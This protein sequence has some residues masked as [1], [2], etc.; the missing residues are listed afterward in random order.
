MSVPN[1]EKKKKKN[2]SCSRKPWGQGYGGSM[3][4]HAGDPQWEKIEEKYLP[5]QTK[6]NSSLC[7]E[8]WEQNP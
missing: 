2:K 3:A 8:E 4:V 5:H 1:E 6:R 7:T